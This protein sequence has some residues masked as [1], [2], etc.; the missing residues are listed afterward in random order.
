MLFCFYFAI[1]IFCLSVNSVRPSCLFANRRALVC[2][3]LFPPMASLCQVDRTVP[4]SLTGLQT[5]DCLF[6]DATQC[7]ETTGE[8]K[9]LFMSWFGVCRIVLCIWSARFVLLL[10]GFLFLFLFFSDK[11]FSCTD[12]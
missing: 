4:K 2:V 3:S 5:S 10:L 9:L 7:C 1:E 12:E 6:A 8:K 11:L